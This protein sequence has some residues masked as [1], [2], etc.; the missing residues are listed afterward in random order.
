MPCAR[1]AMSVWSSEGVQAPLEG[2]MET[3]AGGI[4]V[5][6]WFMGS[7]TGPPLE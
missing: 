5:Y 7:W 4:W 6:C 2:R 3:G 1:A